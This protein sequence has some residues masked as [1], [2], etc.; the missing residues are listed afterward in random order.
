MATSRAA[1]IKRTTFY[2]SSG[3]RDGNHG[4]RTAHNSTGV[5]TK[6]ALSLYLAKATVFER[7][8]STYP[9]P[10]PYLP[11]RPRVLRGYGMNFYDSTKKEGWSPVG[12]VPSPF[13]FY[14]SPGEPAKVLQHV[15]VPKLASHLEEM[16]LIKA[17]VES[18]TAATSG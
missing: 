1:S 11:R 4:S 3:A 8:P 14:H 18:A 5:A 13:G 6:P 17:M 16:N 9:Q 12:Y 7:W 15:E 10:R 2:P